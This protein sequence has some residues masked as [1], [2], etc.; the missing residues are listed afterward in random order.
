MNPSGDAPRSRVDVVRDAQERWRHDLTELGGRN[1][2]LWHRELPLGTFD[3][4]V[5]HPG[6]VAKLLAG[7]PTRLS[8]LVREQVAF[9]GARRRLGAIRDHTVQL[10]REHGLT[11][12]FIAVGLATWS[13]HR[14]KILPRAPVLLRRC[15]IHP[16]DATHRDYI[17]ELD[18]D[19]VFNPVLAHYLRGEAGIDLDPVELAGLAHAGGGFDARDTYE[20]LE[21]L[22]EDVEGFSIGPNTVVSTFPWAKLP[23]VA[24][25]SGDPAGLTRHD[26]VAALAGH[27]ARPQTLDPDPLRADDPSHE[28]SVLDAD[29]DQ[30]LVIDEVSRG[31]SLV[32][33]TP[34]GTGTTQT[35]AN[36]VAGALAQGHNALVVSEERPAIDALRRRL[37]HVGLDD[38]VLDLA[39]DPRRARRSIEELTSQL[40]TAL[41]T[42]E[43]DVPQDPLPA[44]R[45]AQQHL[46]DHD[47]RLHTE[48]QPWDQSLARTHAALARLGR[49]RNPPLSHVRLG[50]PVLRQI[51]PAR[52]AELSQVLTEAAELGVWERGRAEDPW[53]AAELTDDDAAGRARELVAG[54]VGGDLVEARDQFALVCRSAGLPEPV[55]LT[56]WRDRLDLMGRVEQTCDIFR[57]QIYEAPLEEMVAATRAKEEL[58]ERPGAMVRSRLRRQA[59]ALLRPGPP[60]QDLPARVQ[61]ARDERAE[62][63]ALAGRAARPTTPPGWEQAQDHF[64]SLH[65]DLTWLG[66]VLA[67]TPLGRDLL[68]THLDLLLERLLRLDA[69]ADRLPVTARAHSMMQPLREA[70][71]G[72]LVDDLAKRGIA[73]R[74]V[75]AE[76]EMV[77]HASLH[78]HL[79]GEQAPGGEVS[80]AADLEEATRVFRRADR[81]HLARNAA[82]VLRTR[83]RRVRRAVAA[84]PGQV[85]ALRAA[86]AAGEHD[87]RA[88][89][90]GTADVVLAL[91]PLLVGS[92]LVVPATLPERLRMRLVVVE[93]AGRT[94]TAHCVAAIERGTQTVICGDRHQAPP[95]AFTWAVEEEDAENPGEAGA[96]GAE[97]PGETGVTGSVA[98]P[99]LPSLLDEAS[100]V[101]PVR[102]LGTHYR[103]LDQRLVA[104][105]SHLAD[106]A[107]QGYPG[108]LRSPRAALTVI[109]DPQ[110]LV[111]QA[112]DTVLAHLQRRPGQ[113]IVVLSDRPHVQAAFGDA[114]HQALI[115][116]RVDPDL[117]PESGPEPF[118]LLG[119]DHWA[120]EVRDH[121]VWLAAL[122]DQIPAHRPVT[123]LAAVRR[124]L[125]VLSSQP[126]SRATGEPTSS[127]LRQLLGPP[128][129]ADGERQIPEL[130]ADL[131]ERLRAEGLQVQTD[132]GAGRYAVPL[133]IEDPARP[134]RLLVAVDT[135]LEPAPRTPGR[136]RLR[137]RPEQLTRLGWTPAR[138]HSSELF[139]DPA[140][141]VSWL[142]SLVRDVSS[143]P[144]RGR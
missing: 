6:G 106:P 120:G 16:V 115:E 89:L 52:L 108:V 70:G 82:R 81:A 142:L 140:R 113:S 136:E 48:H 122:G 74:D 124:T 38:M 76:V 94:R 71:L 3:L 83:H 100:L 128:T 40:N 73:A 35:V 5:A 99:G 92:P 47:R 33:D 119:T 68:T 134:G 66:E 65:A 131:A 9:G 61:A 102:T 67:P 34:A 4:T 88:V 59:K 26:L 69:R 10:R 42:P 49:Q 133:G 86:A 139:R 1:P 63:E 121:V 111:T 91:R 43:P 127:V 107:P 22:C 31:A 97:T 12:G 78:D 112:L 39:E 13:L 98:D 37:A 2:L 27:P 104:P 79:T 110:E 46:L 125:T 21:W 44:W 80:S 84:H 32:L 25:L 123:M 90:I 8:E 17:L 129:E 75:G 130:L 50:L 103:A 54:L 7:V 132:I 101:L 20:G 23:L 57:T 114:W 72:P 135:D 18:R 118:L 58:A 77:F 30:R 143:R 56:Q 24:H 15:R 45:A 36:I 60:P 95:A 11:T 126:L 55:N 29:H 85:A 62:W 87:L 41:R 138:V 53:Y 116:H 137:L 109:P 19:V 64:A 93:H 96:P 28:L 117:V 144:V 14:A 51:T 141:E 105:L